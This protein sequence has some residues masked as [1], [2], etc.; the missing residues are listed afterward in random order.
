MADKSS[1]IQKQAN[2]VVFLRGL[3][4]IEEGK[5]TILEQVNW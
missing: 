5:N 1:I 3:C 4:N 2:V